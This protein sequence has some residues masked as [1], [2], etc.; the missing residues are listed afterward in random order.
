MHN[1]A[2]GANATDD[3]VTC[4]I[5]E[6]ICT[7][8]LA[9]LKTN[10]KVPAHRS[11]RSPEGKT[12]LH[13]AAGY[14]HPEV[15]TY[16]LESGWQ[17][18]A[19]TS[20]EDTPL[21]CAA[22]AY[23]RPEAG[24]VLFGSGTGWDPTLP[25]CSEET[26]RGIIQLLRIRGLD[27]PESV[28]AIDDLPQEE[29]WP[30][31]E[32]VLQLMWDRV[33]LRRELIATGIPFDANDPTFKFIRH[34]DS[35]YLKVANLLIEAGAEV[36]AMN[37]RGHSP[38]AGAVESNSLPIV[39]LLLQNKADPNLKHRGNDRWYSSPMEDALEGNAEAAA[40]LYRFGGRVNFI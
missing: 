23:I 16:L 29:R 13:V 15:V 39:E 3:A 26:E 30:L 32:A 18:Y 19:R 22:R 28:G 6:A 36:D 1:S 33:R 9:T 40:L 10:L 25:K 21:H 12:L 14:G 38:L 35:D 2:E 17:V 7:G 24:E 11:L 37:E 5:L 20:S 4:C 8:D 31:Y 27:A 34:G